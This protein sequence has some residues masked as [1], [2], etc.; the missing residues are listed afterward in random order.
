[1]YRKTYVEID[2]NILEKNIEAIVNKYDGYQHYIGVV[3]NNAYHHGIKIV[4]TL[5]S[6]GINYLAVSSLEEA[7]D[8]RKYNLEIPILILEP[9]SLEYIDD[10]INNNL[11]L[12]LENKDY[13]DNLCKLK[14]IDKLKVHLKIDSGMNRL[15]FKNK[16]E[17]K[18]VYELLKKTKNI[19]VEGIYTHLATSG[20]NDYYY[21]KQINCFKELTSE[22][23][24]EEIPIVHVDRSLTLVKHKKLDFVNG[25][26]LGIVMYGFNNSTKINKGFKAF[27]REVKRNRFLKKYNVSETI[28][29][30]DLDVKPVF[31]LY[32]SV[33][34]V[35][36]V[37]K[38]DIVG[39]DA[40]YK[41]NEDGYIA[42]IPCGYADGV[43]KAFKYVWIK[44][45]LY[46]IVADSSDMIMVLVDKKVKIDDKV[47]IIGDNINIRDVC[48]RVGLNSYQLFNQIQNRVVRVYKKDN[49]YLEVKY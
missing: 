23:D 10:C 33:L 38:G 39:Y 17:V 11:T 8:I 1:M 37:S 31:K 46:E 15:G 48:K 6:A 29:E 30:N 42:T 19:I 18:E 49:E 40:L 2:E 13:V 35:R 7:L 41:V 9:I 26:R 12:T 16:K 28:R 14:L 22:I 25:V 21:D 27:L 32:S 4:N 45:K 3:K 47:E 20:V 44:N 24:L 43:T 36:K 34:S 5:I